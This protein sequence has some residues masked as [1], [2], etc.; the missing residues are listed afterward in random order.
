MIGF[1]VIYAFLMGICIGSF[2]NVMVYRMPLRLN[3]AKGRSFCPACK[4]TLGALDLF[5]LFSFLFLGARCRYCKTKISWQ[6][7]WV[8]LFTGL[9]YALIVY[10]Y[11]PSVKLFLYLFI[12]SLLIV[13]VLIDYQQM[14]IDN[15][16]TLGILV[17]SLLYLGLYEWESLPYSLLSSL[18]FAAP[19]ISSTLIVKILGKE[20]F[21]FG[22]IK[23][24]L[25]LGLSVPFSSVMGLLS[26]LL[27]C[28]LL[29]IV[30]ISIVLARRKKQGKKIL[31]KTFAFADVICV[32]YLLHLVTSVLCV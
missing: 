24:S 25:A 10:L 2:L 12:L 20:G 29:K 31:K 17:S 13:I 4:H 1:F 3:L 26:L 8:E 6:Y 32:T 11:F 28:L 9:L 5:P 30:F 27:L 18:A 14:Y 23:L 15:R 19:F 22:D 21:G 7:F 16:L